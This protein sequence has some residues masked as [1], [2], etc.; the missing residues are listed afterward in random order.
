MEGGI[1]RNGIV[2]GPRASANQGQGHHKEKGYHHKI[3]HKVISV[4]LWLE[5]FISNIMHFREDLPPPVFCLCVKVLVDVVYFNLMSLT[6]FSGFPQFFFYI[7]FL[8]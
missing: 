5:A 2:V 7:C 1:D 6:K 4:C 3:H 8:F